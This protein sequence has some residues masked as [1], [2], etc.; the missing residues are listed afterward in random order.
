MRFV[1]VDHCCGITV[2]EFNSTARSFYL[3]IAEAS[4][5]GD[6][7]GPCERALFIDQFGEKFFVFGHVAAFVQLNLVAVTREVKPQG[8]Q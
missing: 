4:E 5:K 7:F 2:V 6:E 3:A 1:Q 8:D